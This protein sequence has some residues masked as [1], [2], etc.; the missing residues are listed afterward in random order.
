[1]QSQKPPK[2]NPYKIEIR[3][4]QLSVGTITSA[5]RKRL[6]YHSILFVLSGALEHEVDFQTYR[7]GAGELFIIPRG[8]VHRRIAGKEVDLYEIRFQDDF[9]SVIQK[10]LLNGFLRYALALRKLV[11]PVQP[12][13]RE[14]IEG[15]FSL[16]EMEQ[17][18]S[19][20]QN[21]VFLLQNLMLALLNKLEGLIQSLPEANSFINQ[22][23]PFQRFIALVDEHFV[24]HK[25]LDFYTMALQ[26]TSRKLNE[27]LKE[28]LGQTANQYIIGRTMTE[29]KRELCF[30]ERS[31]KEIA[32][33]LGY[34][35]QY[36]FSRI[37]KKRIGLSPE[38]FR[39]QFAQ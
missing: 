28:V 39:T 2:Q 18:E 3:R 5:E 19:D 25:S 12:H 32:I 30:T 29:A 23:K 7:V 9:F 24:A 13:Q 11:I 6:D 37:F 20:N 15:Y 38:Q 1:M 36:Y 21:Q 33:A 35:N 26:M 34:D 8:C 14:Q 31:I 16:L 4:Y 22:R 10:E 17:N 27:V